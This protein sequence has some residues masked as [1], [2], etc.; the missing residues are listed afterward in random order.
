MKSWLRPPSALFWAIVWGV[1]VRVLFIEVVLPRQAFEDNGMFFLEMARSLR[2]HGDPF[3]VGNFSNRF[4]RGPLAAYVISAL[5]AVM[6]VVPAGRYSSAIAG[7]LL[8]PL[9]FFIGRRL[10]PNDRRVAVLA[11]FATASFPLLI[12]Y[13]VTSY[14][15]MLACF[16]F[17]LGIALMLQAASDRKRALL[18]ALLVGMTTALGY[19]T[20]PSG[21]AL[22]TVVVLVWA[23]YAWS[24]HSG[25]RGW[26]LPSAVSV[27]VFALM[28]APYVLYLSRLVGRFTF[29]EKAMSN[30]IWISEGSQRPYELAGDDL[31]WAIALRESSPKQYILS[32]L[33]EFVPAAVKGVQWMI[34]DH[35]AHTLS[36]PIAAVAFYGFVN[37]KWDRRRVVL[38]VPIALSLLSI[39]V[40]LS[41]FGTLSNAFGRYLIPIIVPSLVWFSKGLFEL[42]HRAESLGTLGRGVTWSSV[43]S[44]GAVSVVALY[45]VAGI[46]VG[47]GMKYGRSLDRAHWRAAQEAGDWLK[48][49]TPANAVVCTNDNAISFA[50]ARSS[51]LEPV[52]NV[53]SQISSYLTRYSVDYV[54][55]EEGQPNH[56][57]MAGLTAELTLVYTA[58]N[59]P[60]EIRI[61]ERH[62]SLASP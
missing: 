3:A 28:S 19:L 13:S 11:S 59:A 61:F 30:L 16:W 49:N 18:Y 39:L 37:G 53:P 20:R 41:V 22:L 35:V 26:V 9:A 27:A 42:T 48:A 12:E 54:V 1:T 31:V 40:P 57:S 50:S 56:R 62:P 60:R 25:W 44:N 7:C 10:V 15:D 32:H 21:L 47:P 2:D 36:L 8:I 52:S 6:D 43:L 5:M 51:V 33:G 23:L 38:E 24:E 45:L 46:A 29:T 58:K 55:S 34:T 4:D 17:T 14:D